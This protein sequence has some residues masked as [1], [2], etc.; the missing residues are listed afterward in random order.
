MNNTWWSYNIVVILKPV[1]TYNLIHVCR[2]LVTMVGKC[3]P[4]S[5]YYK[6][7]LMPL[8]APVAFDNTQLYG[9]VQYLYLDVQPNSS[10]G[11]TGTASQYYL[12]CSTVVPQLCT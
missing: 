11:V 2:P 4:L 8:V 1:K 3:L 7:E 9:L 10:Q 12:L 6:Y 5:I